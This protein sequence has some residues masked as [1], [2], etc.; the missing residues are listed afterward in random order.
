MPSLLKL[1]PMQAVNWLERREI[2]RR[3][4]DFRV[5]GMVA[6][7]LEV[8]IV[9]AMT[10]SEPRRNR[11]GDIRATTAICSRYQTTC[12]DS[13]RTTTRISQIERGEDLQPFFLADAG[14][15]DSEDRQG[16]EG[17][18]PEQHLHQELEADRQ[19][20]DDDFE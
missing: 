6:A 13:P 15:D 5:I 11:S 16:H 18:H 19:Q 10:S 3:S 12:S 7:V 2:P 20:V 4:S 1:V 9:L 14:G 8:L 17:D